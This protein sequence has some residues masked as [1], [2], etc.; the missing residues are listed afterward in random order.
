MPHSPFGKMYTGEDPRRS[1]S[2]VFDTFDTRR[3]SVTDVE[4]PSE[5][6]KSRREE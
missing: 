5:E 6:E 4:S 1:G 2:S 3:G